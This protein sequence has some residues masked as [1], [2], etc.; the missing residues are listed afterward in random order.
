MRLEGFM[1]AWRQ[2]RESEVSS[3]QIAPAIAP[4][5]IRSL[6]RSLV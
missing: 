4:M 2:Q 6:N 3:E 1:A 5:A